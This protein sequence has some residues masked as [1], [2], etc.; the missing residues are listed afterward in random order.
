MIHL[1]PVFLSTA[2]AEDIEIPFKPDNSYPLFWAADNFKTTGRSK[3]GN[4]E[5]ALADAME[6]GLKPSVIGAQPTFHSATWKLFS[7]RDRST[8]REDLAT[9]E[10]FGKRGKVRVQLEGTRVAMPLSKTFMDIELSRADAERVAAVL[11]QHNSHFAEVNAQPYLRESLRGA[12]YDVLPAG[13]DVEQRATLVFEKLVK[14]GDLREVHAIAGQL[15][16]WMVGLQIE[17]ADVRYQFGPEEKRERWMFTLT[18]VEARRA[19][20]HYDQLA[21]VLQNTVVLV[22]PTADDKDWRRV[23]PDMTVLAGQRTPPAHAPTVAAPAAVQEDDLPTKLMKLKL[24]LDAGLLTQQE[25]D[26]KKQKL[27]DEM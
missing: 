10:P 3:S 20:D 25:F 15:E 16:P 12:A 2:M 1:I 4:C 23:V 8:N 27:L 9:C 7:V 18:A 5:E 21:E 26:A 14:M 17:I 11:E 24:A 13:F 19:L 6:R 22:D